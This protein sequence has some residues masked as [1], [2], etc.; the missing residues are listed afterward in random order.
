MLKNSTL[1]I[2]LF[3]FSSCVFLTE[4]HI[5]ESANENSF[6]SRF[7]ENYKS[8]I[9]L[10]LKSS[11]K[12]DRIYIC[13]INDYSQRKTDLCQALYATGSYQ[14]LM[15]N[16]KQYYLFAPPKKNPLFV[17]KDL[18]GKPRNY[19]A[20]VTLNAQEISYL[21][22]IN[23]NQVLRISD[24]ENSK[25]RVIAKNNFKDVEKVLEGNND[26][27][28]KKLFSGQKLEINYLI[29]NYAL[30]K[31]YVLINLLKTQ[32]KQNDAL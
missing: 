25:A 4:N 5:Q 10:K 31:K 24:E 11:N 6:L 7:P 15:I 30:L 3:F 27:E 14:I 18:K 2:L 29:N 1:L 22:E 17:V 12:W 13:E 28:Q 19:F 23:Y 32:G 26:E 16:P 9:L 21:G 20:K 8:I